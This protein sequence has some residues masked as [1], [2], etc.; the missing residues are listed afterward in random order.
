MRGEPI[1]L[2]ALYDDPA[3][4]ELGY[5]PLGLSPYAGLALARFEAQQHT[6]PG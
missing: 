2:A 5:T 6:A 3:A 1:A 4:R